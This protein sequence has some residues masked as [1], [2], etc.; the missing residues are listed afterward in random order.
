MSD[1]ERAEARA[2]RDGLQ[3]HD[4]LRLGLL[5]PALEAA[6]ITREM[7][8][9]A[10]S[11][12]TEDTVIEWMR[13]QRWYVREHDQVTSA[14]IR[15]DYRMHVAAL[16]AQGL[17]ATEAAVDPKG[18]ATIA[19]DIAEALDAERRRREGEA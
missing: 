1:D 13:Q 5:N 16:V 6:G 8:H 14:R 3:T 12:S 17:A 15:R 11:D 9:Q 2:I 18:L 10:I 4:G 7:A 19:W